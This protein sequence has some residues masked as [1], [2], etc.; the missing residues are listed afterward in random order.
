MDTRRTIEQSR[1]QPASRSFNVVMVWLQAVVILWFLRSLALILWEY[2][3][4]FPVNFQ[5]SSFLAGRELELP[6]NYWPAFY[7]HLL[8]APLTF[9]FGALLYFSTRLKLT[10]LMHRR[11]GK[12]QWIMIVLFLTPSSLVMACYSRG[13]LWSGSGL[14]ILAALTALSITLAAVHVQRQQYQKHRYWATVCWLCLLSTFVLRMIMGLL[15]A[16]DAESITAYRVMAWGS[17]LVPIVIY[18]FSQRL[19]F[20][21][22]VRAM[23]AIHFERWGYEKSI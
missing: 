6:A 19:N 8:V 23:V 18:D 9:V 13:G 21:M 10:S 7:V 3:F 22:P 14:A 12:I 17:W 2:R 5:Q 1:W 11:L 20:R 4:Y 16:V 15:Y